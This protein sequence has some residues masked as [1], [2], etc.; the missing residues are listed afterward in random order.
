MSV[1]EQRQLA[2]WVVDTTAGK[3]EALARLERVWDELTGA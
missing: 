3:H 2:D 1:A